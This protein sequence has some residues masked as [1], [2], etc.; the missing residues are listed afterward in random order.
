MR[1]RE[2]EQAEQ[3]LAGERQ[4]RDRGG[5]RHDQRHSS[6]AV[7]ARHRAPNAT[8]ALGWLPMMVADP[9]P[10]EDEPRRYRGHPTAVAA[11]AVLPSL[12]PNVAENGN[13]PAGQ[14]RGSVA[15]FGVKRTRLPPTVL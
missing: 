5:Q 13:P 14:L 10:L 6:L 12:N 3:A 2:R 4:A 7:G 15:P 8:H 1:L 11:A 9:T